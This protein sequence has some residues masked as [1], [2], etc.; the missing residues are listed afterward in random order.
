MSLLMLVSVSP[1]TGS[2]FKKHHVKTGIYQKVVMSNINAGMCVVLL[3]MQ[4]NEKTS[5][6]FWLCL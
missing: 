5:P 3:S 2:E 4:R 6:E 1:V